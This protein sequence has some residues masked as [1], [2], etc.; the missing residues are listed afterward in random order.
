MTQSYA[1]R[2]YEQNRDLRIF[3]CQSYFALKL[4]NF[5]RCELDCLK[6]ELGCLKIETTVSIFTAVIVVFNFES[7]LQSFKT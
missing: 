4:K 1:E 6:I 2:K 5:K 7:I 3:P